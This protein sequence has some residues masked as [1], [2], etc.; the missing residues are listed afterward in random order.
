MAMNGVETWT[1]GTAD[2]K[3]LESLGMWRWR[4]MEK[5]SWTDNVRKEEVLQVVWVE[6]SMCFWRDSPPQW[7]RAPS[8]TWFLDHTQRRATVG[9]TP[10]DK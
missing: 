10:L 8:F 7:S 5:L 3:Y 2:Q 9:R 6:R 4:R 1:L